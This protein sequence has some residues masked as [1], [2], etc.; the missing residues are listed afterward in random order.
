M[1]IE[2]NFNPCLLHGV[3]FSEGDSVQVES[4]VE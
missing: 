4:N 2:V 3:Q 1:P